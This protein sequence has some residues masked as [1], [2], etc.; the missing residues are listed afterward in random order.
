MLSLCCVESMYVK[1]CQMLSQMLSQMSSDVQTT[2]EL[3]RNSDNVC[4][5]ELDANRTQL[6][7]ISTEHFNTFNKTV[8]S[9]G[10]IGVYN[11]H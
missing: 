11:I 10:N 9:R 7:R 2:G 1:I 5:S 3:R 8:G 4:I 6:S